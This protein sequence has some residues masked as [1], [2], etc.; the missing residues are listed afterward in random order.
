MNWQELDFPTRAGF[1]AAVVAVVSLI[2]PPIFLVSAIVAIGFSAVG[3]QRS[4]QRGQANPVA[5]YVVFASVALIAL[6]VVGNVIYASA[7]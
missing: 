7:N 6:V 2:I 1:I 3:W 5:M 4:R